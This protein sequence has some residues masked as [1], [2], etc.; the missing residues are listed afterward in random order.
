MSEGAPSLSSG[1]LRLEAEC[2]RV[3]EPGQW[4]LRAWAY[5]TDGDA[6]SLVQAERLNALMMST[7]WGQSPT[8]WIALLHARR[9]PVWDAAFHRALYQ[10]AAKANLETLRLLLFAQPKPHRVADATEFPRDD[11]LDGVS[12]G[13][14]KALALRSV[15]K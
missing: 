14:R 8:A 2:Q 3:R 15:G 7:L 6:S 9:L 10:G 11:E 5:L 12:L 13:E 4:H 1:A